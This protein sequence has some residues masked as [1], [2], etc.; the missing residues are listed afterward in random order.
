MCGFIFHLGQGFDKNRKKSEEYIALRGPDQKNRILI[1]EKKI[2]L[3]HY[4]LSINTNVSESQPIVDDDFLMIYNGELFDYDDK[5]ICKNYFNNNSDLQYIF[6]LFKEKKFHKLS[7]LNGFWSLVFFDRK[8]NL[9]YLSRDHL[10]KKPLFYSLTNNSFCASTNSKAIANKTENLRINNLNLGKY[11][12][13]GYI[14]EPLSLFENI[15]QVKPGSVLK[16]CAKTFKLID[17]IMFWKP[18]FDTK[19]FKITDDSICSFKELLGNATRIRTLHSCNHSLLSG[20]IDSSII[21]LE[22]SKYKSD[23]NQYSLSFEDK[24]LDEY[25]HA[26]NCHK[27]LNFQNKLI[28]L[29]LT[30]KKY[31]LIKNNLQKYNL[32]LI[33]DSSLISSIFIYEQLSKLGIKTILTGD[34][35]DE[36]FGGYPTMQAAIFGRYLNYFSHIF[37][38]LKVNIKSDKI[39]NKYLPIKFILQR[40]ITGISGHNNKNLISPLFLAPLNLNDINILLGKNYRYSEIYSEIFLL[41]EKYKYL[42]FKNQILI[43]Y[44]ELF[45]KNQ[46][47][48]K[49]DNTSMTCGVEARSPFLDFRI[50]D[51]A[52]SLHPSLKFNF[53]QNKIFLKKIYKDE[54]PLS[55]INRKKQGLSGY[56]DSI[57]VNKKNNTFYFNPDRVD[58]RLSE[59]AIFNYEK[60]ILNET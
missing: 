16:I 52:N 19:I 34:G 6:K 53:F 43:F 29:Y 23:F 58:R 4:K 20:G 7:K 3:S 44:F 36:I 51:F 38:D 37:P 27:L 21:S 15:L 32:E 13:Y 22:L 24:F 11:F 31:N 5:K 46:T 60:F 59:T 55:I 56:H 17:E 54:I 42:P 57:N 1:P 12:A 47:L 39:N 48:R 45:L 35:A 8:N 33:S 18:K 25:P 41:H 30:K 50:V 26:I 9:I 14:P 10:G 28:K 40:F 2:Y 49:L